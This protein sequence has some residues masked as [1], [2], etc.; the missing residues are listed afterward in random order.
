MNKITRSFIVMQFC[1]NITEKQRCYVFLRIELY[2]N[3]SISICDHNLRIDIEIFDHHEVSRFLFIIKLFAWVTT[4]GCTHYECILAKWLSIYKHAK[5]I[6]VCWKQLYEYKV[7]SYM[8][9]IILPCIHAIVF[10]IPVC[11]G[12]FV[13]Q[14]PLYE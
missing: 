6:Q 11:F 9:C 14:K 5:N 7:K 8:T 4:F 3:I 1:D 10:S 12:L 13:C 2:S